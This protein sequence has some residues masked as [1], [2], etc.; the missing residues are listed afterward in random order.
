MVKQRANTGHNLR[1]VGSNLVQCYGKM[2]ILLW[3][4]FLLVV[5][6]LMMISLCVLDVQIHELCQ[7]VT[8]QSKFLESL[9]RSTL[10]GLEKD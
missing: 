10:S 6:Q 4:S 8:I 1:V 7:T 2:I 9:I 3:F 5:I